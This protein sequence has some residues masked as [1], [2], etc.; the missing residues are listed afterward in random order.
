[1]AAL[2]TISDAKQRLRIDFEDDNALITSLLEEATDIVVGYIKKP[3]HEWSAT[4]VPFR[5]KSAILL[6]TGSLY[7]NRDAGE[8]VLTESVRALLHRDRDP[9]LA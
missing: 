5:I 2:A 1:M 4:T 3:D 6:V 7:E 8:A 9:A